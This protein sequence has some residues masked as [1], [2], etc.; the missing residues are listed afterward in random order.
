MWNTQLCTLD[1]ARVPFHLKRCLGDILHQNR[2]FSRAEPTNHSSN[3]A[4]YQPT[5]QPISGRSSVL[6]RNFLLQRELKKHRDPFSF[7]LVLA[8]AHKGAPGSKRLTVQGRLATSMDSSPPTTPP[9]PP[10]PPPPKI[11]YI[12]IFSVRVRLKHT[13]EGE[14]TVSA[15]PHPQPQTIRYLPGVDIGCTTAN[16]KGGG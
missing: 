4:L 9:P 1:R 14:E 12:S 7:S 3:P 2:P 11:W 6:A 15:S 16:Q 13:G 5:I 10:P 8:R